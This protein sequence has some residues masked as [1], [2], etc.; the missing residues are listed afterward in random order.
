MNETSLKVTW[1]PP[2]TKNTISPLLL[3]YVI[4]WREIDLRRNTETATG[5]VTLQFTE[6]NY[7]IEQLIAGSEYEI[8][9]SVINSQTEGPVIYK[10]IVIPALIKS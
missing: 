6:S 2:L 4:T 3:R 5:Q 1:S 8:G 10:N 7:I 9:I